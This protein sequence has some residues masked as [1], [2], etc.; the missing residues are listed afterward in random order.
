MGHG[1]DD[2]D[3]PWL[4]RNRDDLLREGLRPSDEFYA[5][6]ENIRMGMY[7]SARDFGTES[8]ELKI[9]K[10]AREMYNHPP[11]SEPECFVATSAFENQDHPT[12]DRL[13]DFRDEVLAESRL[14]RAFTAA[15]YGG[16]GSAAARAL[17]S[18]PS[19]KPMVRTGLEKLVAHV[20]E[21]ALQAKQTMDKPYQ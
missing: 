2:G 7:T 18:T 3:E 1:W 13:R 21:P 5:L 17:D 8:N 9:D 10:K 6:P 15:Y 20:V 11:R 19:L 14:G 12:V 16:L 4:K